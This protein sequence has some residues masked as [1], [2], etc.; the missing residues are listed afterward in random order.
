MSNN[1]PLHT[2][3]AGSTAG[4]THNFG[5]LQVS[6]GRQSAYITVELILYVLAV[7]GV[8]ITSAVIDEDNGPG[9]SASQ[10]WFYVTLLT[11]GFLVSRGLAKINS[12]GDSNRVL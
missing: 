10:A 8:F 1:D 3:H 4:D 2:Q 6:T 7:L 9:F 11:V 5:D 12:R